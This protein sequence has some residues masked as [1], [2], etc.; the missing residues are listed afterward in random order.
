MLANSTVNVAI[1]ACTQS[2]NCMILCGQMEAYDAYVSLQWLS[3]AEF[4]KKIV[5]HYTAANAVLFNP[6]AARI[7]LMA[8]DSIIE[9]VLL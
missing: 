8:Y 9:L 4:T 1:L 2:D 7:T 6:F 3:D 5:I